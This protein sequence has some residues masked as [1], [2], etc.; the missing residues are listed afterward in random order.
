MVI[1]R[2][3]MTAKT[4]FVDPTVVVVVKRF[5]AAGVLCESKC[6]CSDGV[7]FKLIK[8]IR[9]T[10]VVGFDIRKFFVVSKREFID[11]FLLD[12]FQLF[13]CWF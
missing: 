12:L 2:F 3:R 13:C 1:E 6:L 11:G 9:N 10:F 8:K 7:V 4:V 5:P